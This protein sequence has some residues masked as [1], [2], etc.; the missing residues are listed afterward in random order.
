MKTIIAYISQSGNTRELAEGLARALELDKEF[1]IDLDDR[2]QSIK[3]KR[4]YQSHLRP[5]QALGYI[6]SSITITHVEGS[7]TFRYKGN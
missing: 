2:S 4:A 5:R 3:N 1:L 6:N 7:F